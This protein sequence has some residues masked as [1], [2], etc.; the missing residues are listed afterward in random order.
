MN[1][2]GN[3]TELREKIGRRLKVFRETIMKRYKTTFAEFAAKANIPLNKLKIYEDGVLYPDVDELVML[4]RTFG[5]N[6]NWLF[7]N[8]G[9]M[10]CFMD[11]DSEEIFYKISSKTF[12]NMEHRKVI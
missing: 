7:G 5:L 2:L 6:I 11:K 12:D 1:F 4:R 10:Y 9:N 8:R 3:D